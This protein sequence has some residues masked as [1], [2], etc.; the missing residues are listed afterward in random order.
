VSR[1]TLLIA[2]VLAV[3]FLCTMLVKAGWLVWIP[4][5]LALAVFGYLAGAT[6]R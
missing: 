4:V 3:A 2:G 1:N 6:R 5:L